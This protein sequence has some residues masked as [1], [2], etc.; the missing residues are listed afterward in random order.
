MGWEPAGR[1]FCLGAVGCGAI[2]DRKLFT[3]K[4]E[5]DIE[6]VRERERERERERVRERERG[7]REEII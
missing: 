7:G 3:R 5:K 6:S 2:E 1:G 4:G